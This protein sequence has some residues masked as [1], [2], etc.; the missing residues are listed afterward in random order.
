MKKPKKMFGG[1]IAGA[2]VPRGGAV[3]MPMP[4]TGPVMLPMPAPTPGPR[5]AY[6]LAGGGKIDGVAMRGKTRGKL[7]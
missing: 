2:R 5:R 7:C 1:G 3:A 4:T 6:G